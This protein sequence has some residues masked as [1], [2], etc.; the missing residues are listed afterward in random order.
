MACRQLYLEARHSMQQCPV[1]TLNASCSFQALMDALKR[2][3]YC[4]VEVRIV[5]LPFKLAQNVRTKG[6]P[7]KYSDLSHEAECS[8][9][10]S[11]FFPALERIVI[12]VRFQGSAILMTPSIRACFD[13]PHMDESSDSHHFYGE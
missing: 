9:F 12:P 7:V 5:V 13:A 8:G 11:T 2:Q 3:Q 1:L 6:Q 10:A 4:F